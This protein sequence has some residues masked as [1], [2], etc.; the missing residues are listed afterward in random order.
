LIVWFIVSYSHEIIS[1][2]NRRW[3]Q[4]SVLLFSLHIW[5]LARPLLALKRDLSRS[6]STTRSST[7][8]ESISPSQQISFI[9]HQESILASTPLEIIDIETN[10]SFKTIFDKVKNTFSPIIRRR[11]SEF[12]IDDTIKPTREHRHSS[13]SVLSNKTHHKDRLRHFKSV[14]FADNIEYDN[15]PLKIHSYPIDNEKE[16]SQTFVDGNIMKSIDE[17]TAYI[18]PTFEDNENDFEYKFY[19]TIRP[20][21]I[22]I[23]NGKDLVYQD[24]SAEIVAYVLKNALRMLEKEDEELLL[25]ENEKMIEK[26]EDNEDII[27]LK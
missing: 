11:T 26:N 8:H 2:S 13:I 16:L 14:S 15:P 27:D 18:S 3:I 23:G 7:D 24:L 17:T 4:S 19:Q 6:S 9:T 12:S 20:R 10:G 5:L 25:I 22:S 1:F 21:R